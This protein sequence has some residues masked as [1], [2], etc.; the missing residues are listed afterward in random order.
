MRTASVATITILCVG[1]LV[2]SIGQV[3]AQQGAAS[4]VISGTVTA[5]AGELT[6]LRVKARDT[7]NKI[8][9]TVFTQQGRYQIHNLP[10]EPCSAKEFLRVSVCGVLCTQCDSFG[11][12]FAL[13]HVCQRGTGA[14]LGNI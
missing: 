4:G 3:S 10:G 7:V 11:R 9:Y 2:W 8:A 6:A 13:G 5:D 1:L 14:V 12:G